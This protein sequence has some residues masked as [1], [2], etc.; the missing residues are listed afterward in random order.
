M[1]ATAFLIIEVC[2]QFRNNPQLRRDVFAR[3]R[4]FAEAHYSWERNVISTEELFEKKRIGL[5]E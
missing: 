5:T 3:C 1:S 2:Q 4:A